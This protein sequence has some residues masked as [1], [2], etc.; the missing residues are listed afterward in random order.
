V[1]GPLTV[2]YRVM[3]VKSTMGGGEG[4]SSSDRL[5]S[6]SVTRSILKSF[7]NPVIPANG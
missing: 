5:V 6:C 3:T 4:D 1:I 7:S 2:L